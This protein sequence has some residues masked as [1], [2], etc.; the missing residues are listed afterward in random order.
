MLVAC[1][2]LRR[3]LHK[4]F[5]DH[6][7]I[8][9]YS[10]QLSTNVIGGLSRLTAAARKHTRSL[11]L[12]KLLTYVDT[13]WGTGEGYR[14]SGWD[15]ITIT[16]NRFWWT[17]GRVRIDRFKI[18]ADSSQGLTEQQVADQHGVVKIWGCPNLVLTTTA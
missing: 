6:M 13:R 7:E 8:A 2:S 17:D 5:S 4:K 12:T 15:L 10:T 11:G 1:M 14:R 9:R 16:P 18:R 3:P